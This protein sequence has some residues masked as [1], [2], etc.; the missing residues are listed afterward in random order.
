MHHIADD[1]EVVRNAQPRRSVDVNHLL[2]RGEDIRRHEEVEIAHI[3]RERR[4]RREQVL[5]PP[6]SVLLLAPENPTPRP[7]EAAKLLLSLARKAQRGEYTSPEG[8][9]PYQLLC[10]WLEVAEQYAEKVGLDV[11]D[12]VESNAAIARAEEAE[13]AADPKQIVEP[14][15]IDGQLIRFA[16][17]AVT[18]NPDGKALPAYDEDE[19]PISTRKLNIERIIK[20]DGLEIYNHHTDLTDEDEFV[21]WL[22]GS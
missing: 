4:D 3:E 15:K 20:K 17:P 12:T 14:A 10:E 6:R 8:K 13:Q 16:G 5:C 21:R 22:R 7:L 9:S 18:V 1:I 11:D 2:P 19:D